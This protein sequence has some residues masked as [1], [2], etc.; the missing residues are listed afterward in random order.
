MKKAKT[1]QNSHITSTATSQVQSI[2]LGLDVHADSIVAVR[3][4]DGQTPQPAQR[5]SPERFLEWAKK[6][7]ALAKKVHACYEAGPLGYS[8]QRTLEVLGIVCYVV[9]PRDWDQYGARVKTDS[10]D[11]HEL[12]LCLDRYVSG[13]TKAFCVVRVPTPEEEQRRSRSRHRQAVQ[14][15]KQRLAAQGRSH[16]LYYGHRLASATWWKGR[17]WEELERSLPAHLLDLLRSLRE[18]LRSTEK[19]LKAFTG[20]IEK[21]AEAPLPR[22]VGKLTAQVLEREIGDWSRFKNRRQVAS[23]TGLCPSEDSSGPRRFQGHVNKH[24]NRR[25]RPL[26]V[27]CMWRLVHFQPNY[28]LVRKWRPAFCAPKVSGAR[29][30]QIIA[31]MARQ[32][33]VDWWRIRTGRTTAESVGLSLK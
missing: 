11:A 13:N 10:R 17:A 2:N 23:Y 18:L 4:V 9:R 32:F 31:A 5:F 6:Q 24:G 28:R 25:V 15:H 33:A 12:A 22:G 19:E 27:E 26:L 8:L 7:L 21:D 16:A 3:I 29:R 20:Q 1:L 14:R 30:K